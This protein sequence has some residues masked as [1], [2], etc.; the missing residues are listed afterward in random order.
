MLLIDIP[1][2]G[3]DFMDFFR[4]Q[5][6]V[7]LKINEDQRTLLGYLNAADALHQIITLY[8]TSHDLE[9]YPNSWEA[10]KFFKHFIQQ[11]FNKKSFVQ[12]LND[13]ALLAS[14]DDSRIGASGAFHKF[15]TT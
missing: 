10:I 12:M 1:I 15:L 4:K 13:K 7:P 14:L 5:K 2:I 9:N 11:P 3:R 8:E 6:P